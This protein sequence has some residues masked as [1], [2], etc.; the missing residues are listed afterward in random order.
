MR[1]EDDGGSGGTGMP[2]AQFTDH[3]E[4]YVAIKG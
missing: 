4:G 3:N 2:C 1:Q